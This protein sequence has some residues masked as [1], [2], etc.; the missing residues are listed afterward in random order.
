MILE[1]YSEKYK[2]QLLSVWENSVLAS[3]HFL[4]SEDFD[5]IKKLLHSLDLSAF[6]IYCLT[7]NTILTGFI[8]IAQNKIEMLFISPDYIGLGLG[9]RLIDHAINLGAVKVDVNEQ[10]TNALAFYQ[11]MG[12]E[13]IGR[14]EKDELG[15]GYPLLQMKLNR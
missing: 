8:S 12:F 7:Q 2:N 11:K 6:D 5:A 3:H 15:K 13:I 14:T 9:K 10:N 4:S 1:K